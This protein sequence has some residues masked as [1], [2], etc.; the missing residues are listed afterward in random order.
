[1]DD[2]RYLLS[3]CGVLVLLAHKYRAL[4]QA[5]PGRRTALLPICLACATA[6]PAF[7]FLSPAVGVGFDRLTGVPNLS[8]MVVYGCGVAFVA[9]NQAMLLY[10][11]HAPAGAWRTTRRVLVV[12]A[13]VLA[14]M[15][16]L[17][18]LGAPDVEHHDDF[19]A[20]F[21]DT[22]YLAHLLVLY[23][24]TFL[25]GLLNV[26]RLCW[27]S[28]DETPADRPWLRRGLRI[29]AV[30]VLVGSCYAV[31]VLVGVVGSWVGAGLDGWSVAAPG[32]LTPAV[33]L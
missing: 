29:N 13:V 25:V 11:R 20:A 3:A 10:W 17:F 9:A 30:G 18:A 23:H 28:A 14:V 31:M 32:A 4:R 19:P 1:M 33:P 6:A 26:V 24:V 5:P 7:V 16:A 8:V 2:L 15:I 21:A 27:R 22:P 12:C